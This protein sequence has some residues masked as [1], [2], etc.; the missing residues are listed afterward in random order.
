MATI[1]LRVTSGQHKFNIALDNLYFD[2]R[3]SMKIELTLPDNPESGMPRASVSPRQQVQRDQVRRSR[4]SEL[5]SRRVSAAN[6]ARPAPPV[7]PNANAEDSDD[8]VPELV[9]PASLPDLPD[10]DEIERTRRQLNLPTR[11]IQE[12][13]N[14]IN[15]EAQRLESTQSS[16]VQPEAKQPEAKQPSVVQPE[17][18]QPVEPSTNPKPDDL[19][20][21][22]F[23]ALLTQLQSGSSGRPAVPSA[24]NGPDQNQDTNHPVLDYDPVRE[25]FVSRAGDP[26]RRK[27]P[28]GLVIAALPPRPLTQTDLENQAMYRETFS[29]LDD[30]L[31]TMMNVQGDPV[32]VEFA[33]V[34][35]KAFGKYLLKLATHLDDNT[36][37]RMISMM[38]LSAAPSLD[39]SDMTRLKSIM[40]GFR[41]GLLNEV[42]NSLNTPGCD[43]EFCRI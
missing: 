38:D 15:R 36:F 4:R 16:V 19:I 26:A 35:D 41:Q 6:I 21:A 18:K 8:S 3:K 33:K 13:Q 14:I 28:I 37:A 9:D 5:P 24:S 43:C 10:P 7:Q 1:R 25:T 22:E 20:L 12:I 34:L 23:L 31:R 17:S 2:E 27:V 11:E 40:I 32:V 39:I 29:V 30:W 42:L